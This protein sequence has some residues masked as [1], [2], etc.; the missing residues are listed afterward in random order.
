MIAFSSSTLFLE[1]NV[2][3]LVLQQVLHI[4]PLLQYL[5]PMQCPLLCPCTCEHVFYNVVEHT[6]KFKGNDTCPLEHGGTKFKSI[7]PTSHLT[8]KR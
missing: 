7:A 4:G 1:V 3:Q 8:S 2:C 5:H 6:L